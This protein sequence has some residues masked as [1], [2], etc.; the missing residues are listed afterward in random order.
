ME[1]SFFLSDICT[2]FI[3]EEQTLPYFPLQLYLWDCPTKENDS[4]ICFGSCPAETYVHDRVTPLVAL[5]II[6]PVHLG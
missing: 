1:T 6:T 3:L 4:A 5:G 2:E